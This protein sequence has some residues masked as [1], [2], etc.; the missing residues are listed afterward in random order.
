MG[1]RF[2]KSIKAFSGLEAAI[3]LIAFVIVA[4]IFSYI[5]LNMGFYS[6]EKVKTTVTKGTEQT[7]SVLQISGDIIGKDLDTIPGNKI[8]EIQLIIR[9]SLSS[10]AVDITP[11]KT[12]VSFTYE[13]GG[14]HNSS[15][16]TDINQVKW[17]AK[18]ND[19]ILLDPGEQIELKIPLLEVNNGEPAAVS[20]GHTFKIEV[21]PPEGHPVSATCKVPVVINKVVALSC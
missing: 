1:L 18:S 14:I 16:Y 4:A 6:S 3:V 8:D 13:E 2:N 7:S 21:I 15:V 10:S 5:V 20:P 19:D 12:T 9:N 11:G 17:L